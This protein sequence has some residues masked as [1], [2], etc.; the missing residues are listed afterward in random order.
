M[1]IEWTCATPVM[2]P[3]GRTDLAPWSHLPG[4]GARIGE[5]WLQRADPEAAPSALLLKLLFTTE[6][7]SIQVHPDDDYAHATGL[8]NGKS[9]AWYI[10]EAAAEAKVALG[11][12]RTL[13]TTALRAAIYDGEL[14]GLLAWRGVQAGDVISVPAGTIH[15]LGAGLVVAEVQQNSHATFRLFD[16]GRPRPLHIEDGVA[17][18][19][20][21]PARAQE[22]PSALGAGRTLVEA[23]RH[24]IAERIE[25]PAASSWQLSARQESWLLVVRGS[26]TIAG[27]DAMIGEALFIEADSIAIAPGPDGLTALV[28][29]PG[30]VQRDL[31]VQA[32]AVPM[33]ATVAAASLQQ[34][35]QAA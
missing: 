33:R 31:L 32:S 24:F 34:Q 11:L 20:A 5:V 14:A 27:H 7:L 19:D 13:S 28:A 3:W 30:P 9:E 26:A 21:G 16:Y 35:G 6:P 8:R 18:A 2:K 12:R 17:A 4:D 10:L 23:N 22:A 25:L 1:T 29:Y 15:A